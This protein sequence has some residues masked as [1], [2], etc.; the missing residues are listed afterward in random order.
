[1][2]KY[3]LLTV[4]AVFV[5]VSTQAQVKI[6]RIIIHAGLHMGGVTPASI[7]REIRSVESYQPLTP[8][9]VG[10]ELPF[11]QINNKLSLSTGLNLVNK[12]MKTKAFAENFK[13]MIDFED[14]PYQNF[15]G[16]FTGSVR[17]NFNNLYLELPINLHYEINQ[18]WSI[19]GGF[20]IDRILSRSFEGGV[21]NAYIRLGLPTTPKIEIDR[22]TFDVSKQVSKTDLTVHAG[23]VYAL[24]DTWQIR[25]IFNYGVWNVVDAPTEHLPIKLHNT[26]LTL[27]AGYVLPF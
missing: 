10:V 13:A 17:S 27:A 22:A 3:L 1:M 21:Q 16:Y 20:A 2:I 11:Y 8:I 25:G 15:I 23:A 4:V 7:P 12:G 9:A 14:T 5:A 26:F 18:K 19:Q 24:N 6:D